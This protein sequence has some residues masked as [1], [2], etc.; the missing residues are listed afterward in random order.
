MQGFQ[1]ARKLQS[2]LLSWVR[3]VPLL[4]IARRPE[5]GNRDLTRA[6]RFVGCLTKAV[7]PMELNSLLCELLG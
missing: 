2:H 1:L 7:T 5:F 6:A 4:A 3:R